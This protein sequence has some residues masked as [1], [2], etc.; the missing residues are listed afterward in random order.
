MENAV[1]SILKEENLPVASAGVLQFM[2]DAAL[3]RKQHDFAER[4]ARYMIDNFTE[5]DYALDA[6]MM[7]ANRAI[8]RAA[9]AEEMTDQDAFYEEAIKQL[10]VVR[11]VYA[12]TGQ[13]GLALNLLGKLYMQQKKYKEADEAYKSVLGVKDWRTLWPEALY[14]RGEIAYTQRKFAE[15]TAYYE[16]IYVM[17]SHYKDWTAKSYVRRA[18]CLKKMYQNEKAV[19]VLEEMLKDP[20]MLKLPEAKEARTL[21]SSLKR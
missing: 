14:G 12:N 1:S 3:E 4:V 18:D 21:L 10:D 13:A 8:D 9:V 15:A 7:I 5:T 6:R 20:D 19:E 2:I 11:T 16:R 17:Y